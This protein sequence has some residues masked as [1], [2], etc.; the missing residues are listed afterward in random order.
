MMK[1]IRAIDQIANPVTLQ[2]N[3]IFVGRFYLVV[4]LLHRLRIHKPANRNRT[5]YSPDRIALTS[6]EK[7]NLRKL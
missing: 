4:D 6:I 3:T 2:N 7:A 5:N 1:N